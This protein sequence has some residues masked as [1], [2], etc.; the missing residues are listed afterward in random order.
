MKS[1][2]F[3]YSY[4]VDSSLNLA[5]NVYNYF[6]NC[7][8]FLTHVIVYNYYDN[9]CMVVYIILFCIRYVILM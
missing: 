7:A 8:T 3:L 6:R 2:V 9:A 4:I 5:D 1:L